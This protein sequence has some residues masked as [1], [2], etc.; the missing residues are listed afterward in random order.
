MY[1]TWVRWIKLRAKNEIAW[2]VTLTARSSSQTKSMCLKFLSLHRDQRY[3]ASVFFCDISIESTVKSMHFC[4]H[5]LE[6]ET[7]TM[8]SPIGL[9][10]FLIF[11]NY[12]LKF[13]SYPVFRNYP[14]GGKHNSFWVYE[15][16]QKPHERCV[17]QT[18]LC[19]LKNFNF[20]VNSVEISPKKPLAQC[21]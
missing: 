9:Y 12:C 21:F 15:T 16:W 4:P 8:K 7:P 18:S 10:F 2:S 5:K 13:T 3:Y 11:T 17:T 20:A 14:Q 1:W 19:G 6:L